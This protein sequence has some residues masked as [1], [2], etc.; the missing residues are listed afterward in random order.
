M[1]LY[2]CRMHSRL[3]PAEAARRVSAVTGP[4]LGLFD[5]ISSALSG[6]GSAHERDFHGEVGSDRFAIQRRIGYRNSFLPRI[7]GRIAAEGTGSDL[8]I[9]MH[10]HPFVA[11]FLLFWI[12]MVGN[13]GGM[14]LSASGGMRMGAAYLPLGMVLF[15]VALTLG[16]FIPEAIKAKRRL[17]AL[18]E[19]ADAAPIRPPTVSR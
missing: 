8:R 5:A 7:R 17:A 12:G 10:V 6:G 14:A 4:T 13:F 1:P 15:A 3:A 16:G 9:W 19:T 2:F 11:V 18:L